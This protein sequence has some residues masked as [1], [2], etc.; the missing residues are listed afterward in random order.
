MNNENI[1]VSLIVPI[2]NAGKYLEENLLSICK[3]TYKN[4]EIILID[5][6]STDGSNHIIDAF[7]QKDARIKII[8][9]HNSGV[10][11]ARN[12][13]IN[14]ATGD[15]IC[16]SDADDLLM[17]DYVSYLLNLALK[18]NVDISLTSEM[19]TTFH[20]NQTINECTNLITG[21]DATFSILCYNVA[22]GVYCKMFKRDFLN[23]NNIR[24]ISDIYIGE[25][26]NFNTYAF[27][28]TNK[29]A[30]GNRKVYFYR[31]DNSNS[32]MTKFSIDKCIMALKAIDRIREDLIIKTTKVSYALEFA[33][34]HTHCDVY[35]WIVNA[36]QKNNYSEICKECLSII[37]RK[38]FYSFMLPI[39]SREKI[40][41]ILLIISPRFVAN[42]IRLRNKRA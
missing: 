18:D 28:H 38:A 8:H 13:G 15:Y 1:L 7:A 24:F 26:F 11:T 42:L 30:V 25:G 5:D 21:E 20:K 23:N 4:L 36:S 22:I 12:T 17:P 31:R 6:G 27:Q 19:F 9:Q 3:Q 10:S 32:A 37:R 34:W 16:F 29:V 35:Y 14:A 2:Y 39:K 41:A 33:N 40:R